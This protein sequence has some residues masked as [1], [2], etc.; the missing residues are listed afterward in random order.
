MKTIGLIGGMSW[1]SSAHYYAAINRETAR[2]RGGLHSAPLI[3]HSVDF[4]PVAELQSL[5][6]WD[7]AGRQL[8]AVARSLEDAG[9]QVLGLATN[10]MH[11][12]A[13]LMLEGV[14]IPFVH[15]ADP[16]ADALLADGFDT[17]GLLGTR[18]TMEMGFYKERLASRG[19]TP[20]VPEVDHTN[21]NG[22]IYDELC[23]GIVRDASRQVYQ[24]AIDRMAARG[25]QAVILGCTEI[26]ML[27]DD[28][29]SALPTYDTTE[30]HARALVGA[31]LA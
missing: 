28:S 19:L 9:A 13:D 18:F 20:I 2:L 29:S 8:N 16:T 21:L 31:A 26:G 7:E 22:I 6:H 1:E 23:K 10:T 12:V 27:I 17:V 15:I 4:A 5:G 14:G 11:V 24:A 3:L 30:L 25:A